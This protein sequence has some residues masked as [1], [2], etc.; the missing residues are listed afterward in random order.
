LAMDEPT[1]SSL[2]RLWYYS[3]PSQHSQYSVS[4][5]NV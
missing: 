4:L 3:V 2:K 1:Q 5:E